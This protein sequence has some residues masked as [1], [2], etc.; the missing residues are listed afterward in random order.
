MIFHIFPVIL[1][2]FEFYST[3]CNILNPKDVVLGKKVVSSIIKTIINSDLKGCMK[4]CLERKR[5]QSVNFSQYLKMCELNFSSNISCPLCLEQDRKFITL[6]KELMQLVSM[7]LRIYTKS[8]DFLKLREL[9]HAINV[10]MPSK[11]L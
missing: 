1:V 5:C 8:L 11:S 7:I 3:M 9:V 6:D 4:Q 2:V 10:L